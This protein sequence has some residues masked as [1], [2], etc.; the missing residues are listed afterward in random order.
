MQIPELRQWVTMLEISNQNNWA[1]KESNCV[2]APRKAAFPAVA[3]RVYTWVA[4]IAKICLA[5]FTIPRSCASPKKP[6]ENAQPLIE[7]QMWRGH[8]E[9]KET[10]L[11]S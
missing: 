1:N 2:P 8:T 6:K 7:K 10:N 11:H 4:S 5:Y 3:L 9:W